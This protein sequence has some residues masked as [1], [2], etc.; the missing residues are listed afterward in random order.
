[1]DMASEL[2]TF[3]FTFTFTPAAGRDGLLVQALCGHPLDERL[4]AG[5]LVYT[6]IMCVLTYLMRLDFV[7]FALLLAVVLC[8]VD[9]CFGFWVLLGSFCL[10]H[11]THFLPVCCRD[12]HNYGMYASDLQLPCLYSMSMALHNCVPVSISS[13]PWRW[14]RNIRAPLYQL[15]SLPSP[16]QV[17]YWCTALPN[18]CKLWPCFWH[19]A[20]LA[21]GMLERRCPRG[22]ASPGNRIA[23]A[24][25]TCAQLRAILTSDNRR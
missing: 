8:W 21:I 7:K 2:F 11:V 25:Q 19:M 22:T 9:R 3:T 12:L 5:A 24:A 18:A 10:L 20:F 14:P 13:D 6:C 4:H 16:S 23:R 15:A 1:M 17:L